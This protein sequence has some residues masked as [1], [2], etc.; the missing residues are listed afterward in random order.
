MFDLLVLLC[1]SACA[2][3]VGAVLVA[4]LCT[5]SSACRQSPPCFFGKCDHSS[6]VVIS[7]AYLGRHGRVNRR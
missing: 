5:Y 1:V 4:V 6:S 7:C 3:I 2:L